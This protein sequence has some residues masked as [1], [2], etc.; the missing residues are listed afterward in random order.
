MI[1]QRIVTL[2]LREVDTASFERFGQTFYGAMQD[3][4]FIPLG[5]MHDGGAEGF[6]AAPDPDV[7]CDDTT[8]RFL[9]VSKQSSYRTKIKSTVKRLREYGRDPKFLTYVTS[10]VVPDIDKLESELST[11]LNCK[12][13]IRDAN[14]IEQNINASSVIQGAYKAYLEPCVSYLFNPGASEMGSQAANH[15]NKTLAV[16]LR[17]EVDQRRGKGDLLESVADSLILW[18][19]S[20]TDPDEMRFLSRNQILERIEEALPTAKQFMRGVLDHRLAALGGK[21]APGGRQIRVYRKEGHYCLP[22]ETRKLVA[23]E[24]ADDDLLKL[25][26]SCD[27][28]NRL[29]AL[30]GDEAVEVASTVVLACHTALE[31][32]FEHQGLQI[33]LF[34]NNAEQDDELFTDV[35]GIL[36]KVVDELDLVAAQKSEC[37][38]LSTAVLRGTFYDS[39]AYERLYLQKLSRTYI[40]LLLL[41]NEPKIVEYFKSVA[42][43][44]RLY[45]GTDLI[46]RALSE[47]HLAVENQITGNMLRILKA[48][49]SDLIL[50]QKTVEEV[51]T[52]LRAQILEFENHYGP[53]ESKIPIQM[54]EYIDRLLI[55]AYFY[56]R[57]AP[58][59]GASIPKSWNAYI[60]QFANYPD[61]SKNQGDKELAAYLIRKFSMSY[62]GSDEMLA[63][64]DRDELDGLTA[65]IHEAKTRRRA[66]PEGDVL[67][68]N[69]AL[70]VLRIFQRRRETGEESPGNPFGF[71][72]WWLTQDGKVRRAAASASIRRSGARFMMRPEFLLNYISLAPEHEEVVKSYRSIFPSVMGVRLSARLPDQTLEK[73]LDQAA[74]VAAYDDERAGAM[75]TTYL[76]KLKGDQLKVYENHWNEQF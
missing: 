50:T 55:R 76:D 44:F 64:I 24:N 58:V 10:V 60:S 35:A 49:G 74:E 8:S 54:I 48:S 6:D 9:Q 5:G 63:G 62:E 68:Y 19:L 53:V 16:F 21:D 43:N 36:G 15:A 34:A 51:A 71:Q 23:A 30:A 1:D 17:Q 59:E 27:F 7:F 28:E 12:I 2:A 61:I 3:R 26:V 13:S 33:A 47:H 38:R 32:V 11:Q 56:A 45:V 29:T 70:H 20:D 57:L 52:H 37:R 39:T 42:E 18:A 66:R 72:T 4:E 73:V 41:K 22:Y 14:F 69:D 65:K 46:I 75:I 67:A 40:L 25:Q 31:R